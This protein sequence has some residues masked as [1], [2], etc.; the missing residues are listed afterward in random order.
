[1]SI[2]NYDFG[3]MARYGETSGIKLGY[4]FVA[5]HEGGYDGICKKLGMLTYEEDKQSLVTGIERYLPQSIIGI[6]HKIIDH[7]YCIVFSGLSF[8]SFKHSGHNI[9]FL[10]LDYSFFPKMNVPHQRLSYLI[11]MFKQLKTG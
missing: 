7:G 3:F 6:D 9:A 5:E 8:L 11:F 1:M 2:A 10:T 4:D